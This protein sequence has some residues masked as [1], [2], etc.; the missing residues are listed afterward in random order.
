MVILRLE[1]D[2]ERDCSVHTKPTLSYLTWGRNNGKIKQEEIPL[3][4][5]LVHDAQVNFSWFFVLVA[6]YT[7]VAPKFNLGEFN[8]VPTRELTRLQMIFA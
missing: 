1:E 8:R 7:T 5:F 4:I 6:S 3:K 2:R